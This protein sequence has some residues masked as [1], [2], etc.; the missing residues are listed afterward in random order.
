MNMKSIIASILLFVLIIS[1]CFSQERK[2]MTLEDLMLFQSM[3]NSSLSENGKWLAYEVKTE[4]NNGLGVLISTDGTKE[5]KIERGER[6]LFSINSRWAVFT[7]VPTFAETEKRKAGEGPYN[8]LVLI[9]LSNGHRHMFTDVRQAAFSE[10]SRFL[11]IHHHF[12]NDTTLSKAATDKLKKAG[13]PFRIVSLDNLSEKKLEFVDNWTADSLSRNLV[14]VVNDT[15]KANNGL[16]NLQLNIRGFPI[17][18]GDTTAGKKFT[19]FSWHQESSILAFMRAEDEEKPSIESAALYSWNVGR[20]L[21]KL[22]ATQ[23]DA[24][25]GLY[26]PFD[27]TLT[28]SYDGNRLFFGFRKSVYSTVEPEKNNYESVIDS[29]RSYAGVDIWHVNDPRIKTNE[30]ATWN[31]VRRQNMLTVLYTVDNKTQLLA[32]DDVPMVMPSRGSLFTAGFNAEAYAMKATWDG[33]YRDFYGINVNS[34][35]KTLV[36][37]ELGDMASVSPAAHYAIYYANGNWHSQNLISGSI[38]YLTHNLGVPFYD[39][40]HDTPGEPS[41]Y[42]MMNWLDDGK[43]VILYD[44]YDIWLANLEF[45]TMTNITK[46]DGRKNQIIFRLK[47]LSPKPYNIKDEVLLEGFNEKTRERAL[48]KTNFRKPDVKKVLDEGKNLK[49]VHV[50]GDQKTYIYSRESYDE[51]PDLWSADA[52]FRNRIRLTNLSSQ[53]DAFYWG[54]SELVEYNNT[55]G[56][57]LAGVLIKPENYDPAKKYPVLVYYYEKFSQR[58]HDFNQTVINH[59][60][61]FGFYASNGYCI[62]LPDIHFEVGYPGMSAVKSLVPGVHKLIDMGVADKNAIG[63]HGHSWSGYQTAFVVTQTDIF[64]AAIAGAPVSNMTSAYSGIRWGTGLA[65]QFQYERGQSRIGPSM[66][67]NLDLYIENSPVFFA[68]KIKTPLLLMHGDKD[69]AVPWEQSIEMYLAMRRLGKDVIFLQ[70]RDEPHHPQKYPNKIDYTIRM[71]EYFDYHL[72]GMEPAKW[73]KEGIPYLG[74]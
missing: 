61:S 54:K 20:D 62:F 19:A 49:W 51:F 22:L 34:G 2:A 39:E 36:A 12:T 67:E 27:N 35:K 28:W 40:D 47:K 10:D 66:F 58:L 16:Y 26:L 11:F 38:R 46:G 44:K 56:V 9:D 64:K 1:S 74:K 57:P 7:V 24:P 73:I 29:I 70:Y 43:S 21:P 48:Y 72:K 60:P 52:R 69:E 59:R 71:K 3:G 30:K 42:R 13:T 15:L 45:G 23:D 63:L 37:K 5:Y 65:R 68:D 18:V 41:S 8:Q 32:G 53:L 33:S 6:P 55:D 17:Q 25:G 4:R 31:Q 14:F 50:S